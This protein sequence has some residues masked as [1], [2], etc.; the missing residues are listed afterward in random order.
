MTELPSVSLWPGWGTGAGGGECG[1]AAGGVYQRTSDRSGKSAF[2][3]KM[4]FG[5]GFS[6]LN[7]SVF[8]SLSSFT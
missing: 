2:R 4:L 7:F 3:L 8:V 1:W 6:Q 5:Q